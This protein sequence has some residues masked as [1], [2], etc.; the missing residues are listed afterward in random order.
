MKKILILPVMFLFI[1]S[2]AYAVDVVR[3]MPTT[4]APGSEIEV[5]LT[6]SGVNLEQSI[7]VEDTFPN[8]IP[9][10]SWDV[11]G[12]T[13]V[14]YTKKASAKEGFDRHI[15]TFVTAMDP[16]SVIYKINVP[17]TEG[18]Y[19]FYVRWVTP[20]GFDQ[21]ISTLQVKKVTCG[22]EICEG[23]ETS[24]T[25]ALDCQKPVEEPV[26]EPEEQKPVEAGFQYK[27]ILYIFLIAIV[28]VIGM[29]VY[30]IIKT[31]RDLD[32]NTKEEKKK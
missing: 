14:N 25:C 6:I 27:Y 28:V 17:S 22:D 21:K 31:K 18:N 12:A 16:V 4:V 30:Y 7:G 23:E 15:W 26:T 13:S 24:D 2:F 1:L 20:D 8:T 9:I 3:T 19:D 11:I 5:K 29:I 10:N 32:K